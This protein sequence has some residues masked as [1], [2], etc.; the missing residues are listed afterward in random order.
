MQ[1]FDDSK[2]INALGEFSSRIVDLS[3]LDNMIRKY[4]GSEVSSYDENT[5]YGDTQN[6]DNSRNYDESTVYGD[7]IKNIMES[8]NNSYS[9]QFETA[10]NYGDLIRQYDNTDYTDI[11]RTS[12]AVYSPDNSRK[13][14]WVI[15]YGN[16]DNK[17]GEYYETVSK[18]EVNLNLH[19]D[20]SGA[21]TADNKIN[22]QEII[23]E[24]LDNLEPALVNV[25]STALFEEGEG[26][27]EY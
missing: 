7:T 12:E 22:K 2:I 23:S 14:E 17:S 4:R 13:N 25:L 19:I 15:N 6:I 5:V 1:N 11:N 18:K 27:Y 8:I 10:V 20:V 24:L 9:R 21:L 3:F 26:S 16:T